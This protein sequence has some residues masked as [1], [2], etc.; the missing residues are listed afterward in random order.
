MA[1][2]AEKEAG[3]GRVLQC[4]ASDLS[5]REGCQ[6]LFDRIQE[7]GHPLDVLINNAGIALMGRHDE[8][9]LARWE[10]LL[11]INLAS[12][13]RLTAL[14]TPQMIERR[15]GHIIN[16]ASVA[17]WTSDVGLSA[18][19]AS[20]FGLR[21]F[22]VALADELKPHNIQVSAIYP[23]YSRTPILNSPRFGTLAEAV[24]PDPENVP[25]VTN[26]A[27]VIRNALAQAENDKLHIFPD[28]VGRI[29][30][31]LQ[32]FPALFDWFRQKISAAAYN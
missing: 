30:Y 19:S 21:G 17:S 12:P 26:P 11:E 25:G 10:Q 32:K 16:L 29:I 3:T 6:T 24:P 13:M 18:Y 23:F 22:S 31:Q 7:L 14:F 1:L 5:T 28:R 9:P 20:K 8:V 15:Q 2:T 27:D 4:I